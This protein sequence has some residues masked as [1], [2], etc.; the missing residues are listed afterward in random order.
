[1]Y[2]AHDVELSDIFEDLDALA[3]GDLVLAEPNDMVLALTEPV[4]GVPPVIEGL[5][6]AVTPPP[7]GENTPIT[8]PVSPKLKRVHLV[9]PRS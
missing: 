4:D 3:E 6:T 2:I 7:L 1:M 8:P 5:P 9:V